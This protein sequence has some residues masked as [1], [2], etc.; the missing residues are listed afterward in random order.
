M[1]LS[2]QESIV[3]GWRTFVKRPWFFILLIAGM[4]ILY[5]I[6]SSVTD[7]ENYREGSGFMLFVVSIASAVVGAVLEIFLINLALKA[8]DSAETLT[9][10]DGYAT[11]PF[12]QYLAVKILTGIIV[13]VG[14]ILLV[15]PGIIAALMLMFGNYL[16]VDKGLGPIAAMKES[17]RITKGSRWKLLLFV[18][19]LAILNIVGALCV[20]V[21]LL[22][23]IPVTMLAM[24][25]AY[26]TLEHKA[27][28][29]VAA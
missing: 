26:R 29:V 12:W 6:L 23:T 3:F 16:V 21:G 9:L 4:L 22:V 1:A 2:V 24:V 27:N 5:G 8:H 19:A 20:L 13:F 17:M 7:P 25:H 28:E 18:L 15:V 14:F 10:A 11:I